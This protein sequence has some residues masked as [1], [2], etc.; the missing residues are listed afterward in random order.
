MILYYILPQNDDSHLKLL[1][2]TAK[3]LKNDLGGG[4]KYFLFSPLPGEMVEF[5]EHIFQMGWFNHQ[6]V[7]LEKMIRL[8][9]GAIPGTFKGSPVFHVWR[10]EGWR[11]ES[12]FQVE[13]WDYDPTHTEFMGRFCYGYPIVCYYLILT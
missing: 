3:A 5:D 11:H 8:S 4:F 1:F 12:W 6:L 2:L 10:F 7:M 13:R 9:F